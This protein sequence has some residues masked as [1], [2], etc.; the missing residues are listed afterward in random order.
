MDVGEVVLIS[1]AGLVGG[2][3]NSIAG[4][5]SLLLFPALVAGG[6]G[7]VAANVTN[8]VALWPGYLG[9]VAALRGSSRPSSSTP[10]AVVSAVG[11]AAGCA[12]LLL[13]PTRVFSVAV[14]FLVLG[15][16][17]LLALQPRLRALLG[18]AHRDHRG[19]LYAGTFAGA[20]YGGYFGGGLGVVLMAV[21][22][23]T[24]SAPTAE[25]NVLKG[26][27]QLVVAT[28]SLV[29][30]AWFGPV[31][32]VVALVVA[33]SSLAGGVIG[34]RVATR[35]SEPVLRA[36]VVGFGVLVGVWLGIRA[37]G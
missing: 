22:G 21:L 10:P 9:N 14:P 6:L 25:V 26:T 29:V 19:M 33:P 2:F 20:V 12:L 37:F 31:Q 1:G 16:S 4:G 35:L 15:A 11:A 7:T 28:V 8:S 3:V 24:L 18:A 23:L 5:G 34:G 32:W 17:A 27:L 30:F 13:T 36:P